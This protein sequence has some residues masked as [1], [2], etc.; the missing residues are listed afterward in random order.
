MAVIFGVDS[1]K[2]YVERRAFL[3]H[4]LKL[5]LMLLLHIENGK[6]LQQFCR[7]EWDDLSVPDFK[8]CL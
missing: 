3:P 7:A 6:L 8:L 5:P 2:R 4:R 1:S